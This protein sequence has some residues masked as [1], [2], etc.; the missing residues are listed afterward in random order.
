VNSLSKWG[1]KI[2]G[3]GLMK[4][5]SV[6]RVSWERMKIAKQRGMYPALMAISICGLVSSLS[7]SA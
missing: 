5:G 6:S 2:A 1:E 4:R 3:I 7:I